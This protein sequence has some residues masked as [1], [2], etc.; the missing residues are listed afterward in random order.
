MAINFIADGVKKPKL[1]YRNIIV[2]L[3]DIISISENCVGE[4]TYIFCDDNYLLDINNRFLNHDYY[5]DIISFDYCRKN[6]ISGDFFISVD[7][8]SENAFLYCSSVEE[9]FLRVIVHGLLHLLGFTD[10]SESEKDSMR[11]L[12]NKYLV[13]YHNIEN[14]SF[15]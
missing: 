8:V 12:E 10:K 1:K 11:V 7:R 15:K 2:W 14:G 6:R 3:K 9:E 4:L 13:M 5:T